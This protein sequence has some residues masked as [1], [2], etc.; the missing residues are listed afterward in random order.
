V[1]AD[2]PEATTASATPALDPDPEPEPLQW[3]DTDTD[4]G[5]APDTPT[6]T[7]SSSVFD[8]EAP[9]DAT[10]DTDAGARA[11]DDD[12]DGD[13]TTAYG[14]GRIDDDPSI[15]EPV[16]GPDAD[17]PL[18]ERDTGGDRDVRRD[19]VVDDEVAATTLPAGAPPAQ[20][21]FDDDDDDDDDDRPVVTE[22]DVAESES[23]LDDDLA[24]PDTL[25]TPEG[26]DVGAVVA[27]PPPATVG[28]L[29][30]SAAELQSRWD[31][32]QVD[33]VDDPRQAVERAD[34][35]IGDVVDE[36]MR[37]LAT[38]R[39]QLGGQFVISDEDSS[40]VL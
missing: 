38:E 39:E 20:D 8:T 28:S 11:D 16:A 9:T 13:P 36:I 29:V 15:A 19:V 24:S 33:F 1:A 7:G 3:R 25:D 27:D 12:A 30:S 35:L 31:D 22:A 17:P 4:T 23:A 21:R 32:A 40:D 14:A 2:P 6:A 5:P 37:A 26:A 34:G 10:T 18:V